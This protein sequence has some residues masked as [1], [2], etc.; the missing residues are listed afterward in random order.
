MGDVWSVKSWGSFEELISLRDLTVAG[1]RL[2][3]SERIGGGGGNGGG[4]ESEG[5]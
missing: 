4:V 3:R 5:E 1:G 2:I